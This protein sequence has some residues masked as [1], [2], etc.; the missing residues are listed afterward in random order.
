MPAD[1]F[2][3]LDTK[4]Q[5]LDSMMGKRPMSPDAYPVSKA[6][7]E[8]LEYDIDSD[9]YEVMTIGAPGSTNACGEERLHNVPRKVMS[10]GE[11]APLENGTQVIID[12]S[13][14]FPYIDGI[15]ET[16]TTR[17]A[18][19]G[20]PAPPKLGDVGS[21]LKEI[22]SSKTATEY[23]RRPGVPSDVMPGE[24]CQTTPDGNFIAA[25]RGKLNLLY[26]SAKAQIMTVGAYD[27]VRMISED[28]E[29]FHALGFTKIVNEEGKCSL[30]FRAGSDQLAQSG[31]A[32][33][34]WTLEADVG[35]KGYIFDLRVFSSERKLLSRIHLSSDGKITLQGINGVDIVNAGNGP[36][37][38]EVGGD[39]VTKIKGN[40]RTYVGLNQEETITGSKSSTA[41]GSRKEITGIDASH[42]IN[43]NRAVTIG[44]NYEL[45][46][47]GGSRLLAKPTNIASRTQVLNGSYNLEIG[48][49]I[50]GATQARPGYNLFVY[51][52]NITM[53][54]DPSPLGIPAIQTTISMNTKLP[55]SVGIGGTAPLA[56]LLYPCDMHAMR[57]ETFSILMKALMTWLDSHTHPTTWGPSGVPILPSTTP[58]GTL[59]EPCMSTRVMIGP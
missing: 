2:S 58:L 12:Y 50:L 3:N 31:G 40:Q 30:M 54:E 4:Q 34:N 48:N 41:S 43:R 46:I 57:F 47:T 19:E 29:H 33:E 9:S 5:V 24:W 1:K 13:L 26:G 53:G 22:F 17:E 18:V 8:I 27:L 51:N 37:I 55:G 38:E 39:S 10:S 49:P 7:A 59:V 15:L 35:Y 36:R 52:G 20:D 32:E 44:G 14:G 16:N 25:L 45:T 11:I 42:S 28:Y 23:W 56:G 21:S 6:L